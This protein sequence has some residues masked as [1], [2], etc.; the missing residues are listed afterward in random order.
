VHVDKEIF[1]WQKFEY[2]D[3]Q[4]DAKVKSKK[5]KMEPESESEESV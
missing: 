1:K 4:N 3:E 2:G 5:A